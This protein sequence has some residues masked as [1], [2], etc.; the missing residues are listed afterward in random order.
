[1]G[2]SKAKQVDLEAA[3]AKAE[4]VKERRKRSLATQEKEIAEKV[5]RL[6]E[7]GTTIAN[8]EFQVEVEETLESNADESASTP[9]WWL[10]NC[11][12]VSD[13]LPEAV[14]ALKLVDS[15]CQTDEFQYLFEQSLPEPQF[16]ED[17]LKDDDEKVRLYT[18]LPSF[19]VLKSTFNHVAPHVLCRSK[20]LN[21]FQ[22]LILVLIRLR[23]DIFL[24]HLAYR[25][26]I[27]KRTVQ[28]IMNSWMEAMYDCRH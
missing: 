2:H 27:S 11:C 14:E 12:S 26:E 18:G 22:E 21:Q 19:S 13:D 15:Q 1:M 20:I 4:R 5:K 17:Y 25:F 6:E 8:L 28:C 23:L 3:S 24:Q 7:P 16:S 10:S 9:V